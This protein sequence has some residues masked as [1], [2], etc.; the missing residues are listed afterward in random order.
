MRRFS[1]SRLVLAMAALLLHCSVIAPVFAGILPADKPAIHQDERQNHPAV[2]AQP[3]AG[4]DVMRYFND[5]AKDP[6]LPPQ[7]LVT[8]LRQRIKYVF[9]IFNEN[10]SFDNEYGTFPGVN[11]IYSDGLKPRSAADTPGFTQ[12]YT[13]VDGMKRHGPAVQDGTCAEFER[14]R[15]RR[16]FAPRVLRKRSTWW[17]ACRRW[18]GSPMTSTRASLRRAA[19]PTSPRESSSPAW[20]C[21][22]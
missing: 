13:D 12:T 16:P 9:I 4:P 21:H 7:M 3:D 14:R 15:Q 5:P 10:H 1:K 20:S 22:T 2:T 11:G 19:P 18:T 6:E 8:L 17:T